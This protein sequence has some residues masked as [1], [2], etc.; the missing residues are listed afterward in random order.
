MIDKCIDAR[1]GYAKFG[2]VE[3]AL[4][5]SFATDERLAEVR[6]F[7]W[8]PITPRSILFWFVELV[9]RF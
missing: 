2:H 1:T 5:L 8:S 9:D 4:N 7:S 6:G 3:D